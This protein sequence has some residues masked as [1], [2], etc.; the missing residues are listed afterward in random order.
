MLINLRMR[1]KICFRSFFNIQKRNNKG[2]KISVNKIVFIFIY[3]LTTI[4]KVNLYTIRLK[5]KGKGTQKILSDNFNHIPD[6]IY[7]NDILQ[8]YKG[9]YVYD[10]EDEINYIT[11][12]YN[13]KVNFIICYRMFYNLVNILTIDFIDFYTPNLRDTRNMFEGCSNLISLNLNNMVTSSVIDMS[14]MFKNC[15]K[16]TNI[17][18]NNFDISQVT[19]MWLMFYG[20]Y[21][22]TYLNLKNFVTPSNIHVSSMFDNCDLSSFKV[23][24]DR[25]KAFK[26]SQAFSSLNIN[27][28]EVCYNNNI[29]YCKNIEEECP[30]EYKQLIKEKGLCIKKCNF[31][32]YFKYEYNNI[33]INKCPKRTKIDENDEFLCADLNCP[34]FYNYEQNECIEYIPEG[35]FLNNSIEKAIDLCDSNCKTCEEISTKCLSCNEY[36]FVNSVNNKCELCQ[37][38]CKKCDKFEN[39]LSCNDNYI[40]TS[41]DNINYKCYEKCDYY[42]YFDSLGDYIC[43]ESNECPYNYNKL[44]VNKNKCID[45]C[46]K[47]DIYKYE[48]EFDNICLE[49]C[50]LYTVNNN[51]KCEINLYELL[52]NESYNNDFKMN[53]FQNFIRKNNAEITKKKIKKEKGIILEFDEMKISL[54]ELSNQKDDN[55]NNNPNETKIF[56][57]ECEDILKEA[58][59]ISENDSLILYKV[60]I[61]K[62]QM[63]IPRIEYEVYFPLNGTNLEILNLSKCSNVTIDVLLPIKLKEEDIDKRNINSDYYKDICYKA[64]SQYDTDINIEDRKNYYLDNNLNLCEENCEFNKYEKDNENIRCSC[65]VK[66]NMKLFSEVNINKAELIK[67]FKNIHNKMNIKIVKCYKL[68]LIFSE[69]I[70]NYA[71]YIFFPIFIA[72]IIFICIYY[73]KKRKNINEII[74]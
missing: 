64:K 66:N 71:V 31:D 40:L 68:L 36:Y 39:C 24:L 56:I 34:L 60:D 67:G 50:P 16:L 51:Y 42:Y 55:D 41:N 19:S 57:N 30:N 53:Y 13:S 1:A 52:K 8:T 28:D 29:Y 21:S 73:I 35:Y 27:C 70:K 49:E 54:N 9:I 23:C 44:I 62:S 18:L 6:E 10:L 63:K 47:D 20:C 72:H 48:Y 65:K 26:I 59:N 43:I 74:N 2:L 17:N 46:F 45:Q 61:M 7:I 12:K 14:E 33:C 38:N 22:L 58:Y 69:I 3:I 5:I 15:N 37:N 4:Q 32:D 11:I 25:T